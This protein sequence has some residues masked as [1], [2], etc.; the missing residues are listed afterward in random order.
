MCIVPSSNTDADPRATTGVDLLKAPSIESCG[1]GPSVGDPGTVSK[2]TGD[3]PQRWLG[4][5]CRDGQ[6]QSPNNP[7]RFRFPDPQVSQISSETKSLGE[8]TPQRNRRHRAASIRN[9]HSQGELPRILLAWWEI[10]ECSPSIKS[11]PRMQGGLESG[12]P[13]AASRG[14]VVHRGKGEPVS[15]GAE[16]VSGGAGGDGLSM[17]AAG[18]GCRGATEPGRQGETG[19]G[20]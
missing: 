6:R 9:G 15:C 19:V 14:T 16:G 13:R 2:S 17:G 18:Q 7:E 10:N 11:K 8:T 20:R 1:C 5:G 12:E 4:I 3:P